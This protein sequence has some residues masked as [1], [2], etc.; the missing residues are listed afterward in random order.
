MRVFLQYLLREMSPNALL[1][2]IWH[3]VISLCRV[4]PPGSVW[5]TTS[6]D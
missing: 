2:E 3:E 1:P 4:L 6:S 5:M